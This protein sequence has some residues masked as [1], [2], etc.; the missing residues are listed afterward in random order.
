MAKI[1]EI[2]CMHHS[3]FDHGYTHPQ[4]LLTALQ[5]D[6]IEQAIDLCIKTSEYPEESRFRWT[7]EVTYPLQLWLDSAKPERIDLFKKLMKAGQISVSALPMHTT[8]GCSAAEMIYML[9]DLDLLRD[10]LEHNISTAINH[11]VNG[12]PWP[13]AQIMLNSGIDFYI[14][15]INLHFGGLPFQRP[16]PFRWQTSD[17]RDILSFQGEHYAMFSKFFNTQANDT[18]QMQEGIA[19]YTKRLEENGYDRDFAFLTAGNPPLADNNC[20]DS[21]L[22]DLIRRYNDEKHEQTIRFV[23][24]EMLRDKILSD[25]VDML[26]VYRGDW[27]DYW[28]FGCG[29]TSRETRTNRCAKQAVQK[30]E[31]I[32]CICVSTDAHYESVKGEAYRNIL[33]YDEHTWGSAQSVTDPLG[34]DTYS[35]K[36]H[37]IN[38]AYQ[39]A[40]L[41]AYLLSSQMER[42]AENPFQSAKPEGILVVNTSGTKQK[43]DL[44]VPV[45]YLEEGRHLSTLRAKQYIPYRKNEGASVRFGTI[46]MEPFSWRRIPFSKLERMREESRR[47]DTGYELENNKVITPYY[48]IKFNSETGRILQIYHTG[49]KWNMLDENSEWTF[50]E[51]VRETI[52]PRYHK[53]DRFTLFPRDIELGN[54]N[55][56]VWR[57]DWKGRREGA[58]AI[59]DWY[60]DQ[61][62]DTISFVSVLGAP[63][64]ETLK[65]TITF[66]T[67]TP[68]I[69]MNVKLTKKPVEKPEGIYFAFPLNMKEG[70]ECTF[71]TAGEFVRLDRDQMGRV[72][73]DWITVDK[74]VSLYDDER[75]VTLACPDAPMV[76]VGDFNFGKESREIQ[77][78]K[79]PLLLAWPMNNYW[80]VN[81]VADQSGAMEFSYEILPFSKF[82]PIDAYEEGL[83]AET[84]YAIG[85]AVSCREETRGTLLE[86]SGEIV[87]LYIKPSRET[88]GK[89]GILLTLKNPTDRIQ[90]Y[91]FTIPIYEDF[92]VDEVTVQEKPKQ[93]IEV[94][95]HLATVTLNPHDLRLY[96]ILP[97]E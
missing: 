31:M 59:L 12:Q 15:G 35:Q 33:L 49:L 81:F 70:W 82:N 5:C 25:G 42:L 51:F 72:C 63:G 85:A 26:P 7:C 58:D 46:S 28:N 79:N 62:E 57:H 50:F 64:I 14:T 41:G 83:A 88:E 21:Q 53:E 92:K 77:R 76:Q 23:T 13:L 60:F 4:P 66:S 24:P 69:K 73:R 65:Q 55:V 86:G 30:A 17:G 47:F 56:S 3:H 40:D 16:A 93:S 84:P 71:D 78:N 74:S 48:H 87:P 2:W 89:G 45:T 96:R 67:K 97:K 44:D 22:A 18:K 80:D 29:S 43:I 11:D 94:R 37:K 10:R 6:Y 39:A 8:P 32:E 95:D 75:G 68:R 27:T 52:D 19:E 90:N 34:E 36:I 1:K 91:S 38:T 61:G 54:K 20:P 9:R